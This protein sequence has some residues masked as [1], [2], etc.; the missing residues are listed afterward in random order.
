[1]AQV[2]SAC[3]RVVPFSLISSSQVPSSARYLASHEEV[4]DSERAIGTMFPVYAIAG[5]LGSVNIVPQFF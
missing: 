3:G 1:M 4:D 2:R 5:P